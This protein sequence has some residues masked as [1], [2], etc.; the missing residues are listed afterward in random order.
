MIAEHAAFSVGRADGQHDAAVVF[1]YDCDVK[2]RTCDVFVGD[3]GVGS[4]PEE[5]LQH[6]FVESFV[7]EEFVNLDVGEAVVLVAREPGV[8]FCFH[9]VQERDVHC[10]EKVMQVFDVEVGHVVVGENDCVGSDGGVGDCRAV[11]RAVGFAF[12]VFCVA[13]RASVFHGGVSALRIV[14]HD[15]RALKKADDG[16]EIHGHAVAVHIENGPAINAFVVFAEFRIVLLIVVRNVAAGADVA[17]TENEVDEHRNSLTAGVCELEQAVVESNVTVA[18]DGREVLLHEVVSFFVVET[19]CNQFVVGFFKVFIETSCDCVSDFRSFVAIVIIVQNVVVVKNAVEEGVRICGDLIF[20]QSQRIYALAEFFFEPSGHVVH[21]EF[22]CRRV[23]VGCALEVHGRYAGGV[24]ADHF[25]VFGCGVVVDVVRKS[26]VYDVQG[27]EF[28]DH[29]AVEF[30]LIFPAF[31]EVFGKEGVGGCAADKIRK[32]EVQKRAETY[33][34]NQSPH[35][36]GNHLAFDAAFRFLSGDDESGYEPDYRQ[37]DNDD[38]AEPCRE[39]VRERNAHAHKVAGV[40]RSLLINFVVG[41][42]DQRN[43]KREARNVADGFQNFKQCFHLSVL[44]FEFLDFDVQVEAGGEAEDNQAAE[45]E[46]IAE[47]A[48]HRVESRF[49]GKVGSEL[50][51]LGF[52]E[53]L[54][55]EVSAVSDGAAFVRVN[56]DAAAES[57]V[58]VAREESEAVFF[59]HGVG[60]FVTGVDV[61]DCGFVDGGLIAEHIVEASENAFQSFFDGR[62][63]RNVNV[64]AETADET[65]KGVAGKAELAEKSNDAVKVQSAA[66]HAFYEAEQSGNFLNFAEFGVFFDHLE[67]NS[68]DDVDSVVGN[69]PF[70]GG[71]DVCEIFIVCGEVFVVFHAAV[72]GC[73]SGLGVLQSGFIS[74]DE[75]FFAAVGFLTEFQSGVVVVQNVQSVFEAEDPTVGNGAVRVVGAF[76]VPDAAVA[77]CVEF[78]FGFEHTG[79]IAVLIPETEFSF[80]VSV[81]DVAVVY[82]EIVVRVGGSEEDLVFGGVG[83]DFGFAVQSYEFSVRSGGLNEGVVRGGMNRGVFCVAFF[84]FA[85]ITDII[86]AGGVI[87]VGRKLLC[88][89]AAGSRYVVVVADLI[90]PACNCGVAEFGF[91]RFVVSLFGN[92]FHAERAAE[93]D[94]ESQ[95]GRNGRGQFAFA[96]ENHNACLDKGYQSPDAYGNLDRNRRRFSVSLAATEGV[97]ILQNEKYEER[98]SQQVENGFQHTHY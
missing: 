30:G 79:L 54:A 39:S 68:E 18:I 25:F 61:V 2:R 7:G 31:F 53:A 33:G 27:Y 12:G 48:D 86:K 22:G 69:A 45:R 32:R 98:E 3:E 1:D 34:E 49:V 51:D 57:A 44:L 76:A 8:K 15:C 43:K 78:F 23:E 65:C 40:V 36:Y 58:V 96:G 77:I 94:Y 35:G 62:A 24:G 64:E 9:A 16:G 6:V 85:R 71:C 80:R 87:Y 88:H 41:K 66:G 92:G 5:R 56:D 13:G 72:V 63:C 42:Y 84:E 82:I 46:H 93:H 50:F 75:S 47:Q 73:L 26:A 19:F 91:R 38:C 52:V 83:A 11:L 97:G 20:G 29:V 55:Y 28:F 17:L 89:G 70:F 95:N 14:H 10:V 67:E 37:H 90:A 60:F 81:V 59:H 4:V 74:S 21:G